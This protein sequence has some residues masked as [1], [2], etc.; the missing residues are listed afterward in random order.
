MQVT[1]TPQGIATVRKPLFPPFSKKPGNAYWEA[2]LPIPGG[3]VIDP[4]ARSIHNVNSEMLVLSRKANEGITISDNVRIY[5]SPKTSSSRAR[6]IIDAPDDYPVFRLDNAGDIEAETVPQKDR[7][8]GKVYY[9]LE[10]LN[11]R[12]KLATVTVVRIQGKKVRL[13]IEAEATVP[14]HREEVYNQI[15]QAEDNTEGEMGGLVISREVSRQFAIF[16]PAPDLILHGPV[17]FKQQKH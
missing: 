6:L 14:V 10:K 17:T 15:I 7:K 8:L 12:P 3:E 1:F 4:N 11:L 13:G 5:I 2:D 9:D 16:Y